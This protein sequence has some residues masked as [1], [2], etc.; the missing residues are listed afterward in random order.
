MFD[1]DGVFVRGKTLLPST[2]ECIRLLTDRKGNFTVPTVF[3]TNAGNQLRATKAAQLT[4]FLGINVKPDQVVLSHSP[5][6]ML[7]NYHS[8]RCLIS[9][10]G[11]IIDIARNL[12]FKNIVTLDDV[13]RFHPH[14]DV[15][16]LKR[17]NFAVR[18][19]SNKLK[20]YVTRT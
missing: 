18:L 6:K 11:P 12:G 14:L 19:K 20:T 4:N 15:V 13:R 9:G 3:V 1:I 17:R 7:K 16:D 5:L 8:K 2:L 10:Q